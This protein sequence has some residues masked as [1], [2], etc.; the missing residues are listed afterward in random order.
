MSCLDRILFS[1]LELN[2]CSISFIHLFTQM[3]TKN[4]ALKAIDPV[5][6]YTENQI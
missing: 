5:P 4:A 3:P 2:I 6:Q 1:T